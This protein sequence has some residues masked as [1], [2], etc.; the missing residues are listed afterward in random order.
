[1]QDTQK[2]AGTLRGHFGVMRGDSAVN[3]RSLIV[4]FVSSVEYS[5]GCIAAIILR[6]QGDRSC[7]VDRDRD[8]T[9]QCRTMLSWDAVR[10]AYRA[11]CSA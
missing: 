7:E 3:A 6:M 4:V 10:E 5:K 1:M 8:C 9:M 11:Q 2:T